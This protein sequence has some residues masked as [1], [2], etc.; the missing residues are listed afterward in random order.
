MAKRIAVLGGPRCGKTTLIQHLYVEMKI[1]GL[2]VGYALEYSTEYLRD[3]GM[4]ESI[5]EQYGIYL[6]QKRLEDQL[7]EFDYALT[8]YATFVP[9]IYGR[10]MLGNKKR[11]KKETE[12]LKDLYSLALEDIS[13]Y[14]HII[15]LPREFGY[16][17]DGVR[18]Q[19]EG[20]A[21]QVDEAILTFLKSENINFVEVSGSTKERARKILEMLGLEYIE[22][23]E[24]CEEVK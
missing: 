23:K 1:A 5:A 9:Y 17:K 15:F 4:I 21:K 22:T 18:W 14:D 2:N 24:L 16:V 13:K 7:E 6:G 20:L 11:S 19:D 10:F 3:K 8:D 12:I